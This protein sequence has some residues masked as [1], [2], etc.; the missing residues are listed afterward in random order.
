MRSVPTGS[1]FNKIVENERKPG[2]NDIEKSYSLVSEISSLVTVIILSGLSRSISQIN[3]SPFFS[4]NISTN[5][6][7]TTVVTD[8][9]D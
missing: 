7:G 5:A 4:F 1:D 9:S 2:L 8:S 3:L 6:D